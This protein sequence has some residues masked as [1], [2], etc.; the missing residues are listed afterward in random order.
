MQFR[1]N[2]H[3][4]PA[5]PPVRPLPAQ[6]RFRGP[7]TPTTPA[8]PYTLPRAVLDRLTTVLAPF[9]NREPVFALAVFL[10]RYWSAPGRLDRAFPVDRRALADHANLGL[11]EGQVR[12]ALRVL[13]AIGFI[14]RELTAG[15]R[16][17][18]RTAT[19]PHRR[20]ITFRFGREY[21]LAFLTA[22]KRALAVQEARR[23]DRRPRGALDA[24]HLSPS[25]LGGL[26][27]KLP[28]AMSVAR[29]FL[30]GSFETEAAERSFREVRTAAPPEPGS[31]LESALARLGS[32]IFAPGCTKVGRS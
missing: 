8:G 13:E 15:S 21:A 7:W 28:I 17:Y 14:E 31:A 4:V 32:A 19:G 10:G 23:G 2:R 20:P 5:M 24:S 26:S 27:P 25:T 12:G 16:L 29:T 9:R 1:D 18:Q 11:T 6:R 22:N 30:T 3:A